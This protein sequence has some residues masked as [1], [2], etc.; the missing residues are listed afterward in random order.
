MRK[1]PECRL[2]GD[3]HCKRKPT[4]RERQT[5]FPCIRGITV[6]VKS[7]TSKINCNT[8]SQISAGDTDKFGDPKHPLQ[9]LN[10]ESFTLIRTLLIQPSEISAYRVLLSLA[11]LSKAFRN[12]ITYRVLSKQETGKNSPGTSDQASV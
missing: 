9:T 1:S 12:P 6:C 7:V 10:G 3:S 4:R 5:M 2:D 11:L 8:S